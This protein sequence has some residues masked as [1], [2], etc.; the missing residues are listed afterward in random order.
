MKFTFEE[1]SPDSP[2]IDTIWRTQSEGT[3]SFTSFTSVAVSHC[4]IVVTKD[5]RGT[6]LVVRGPETV[7]TPAPVPEDAEFIGIKFKLGTFMPHLPA[8]DLVDNPI[9]LP[10]ASSKSFWLHG[11]AWQF[12][13]FENADTFVD[14]L[15]REGLLVREPIVEA[16]LRGQLKGIS[17]RSVQRRFLRAVGLTYSTVFQ[18]ERARQAMALLEQGVSILD[19]VEQAGYFDQPHLTRSLKRLVGQTPAQILRVRQPE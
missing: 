5:R 6:S 1:R 3:D 12:P 15:V 8:T 16:T 13:D 18:I 4:E 7:A 14:R 10:E 9:Y 2:F 17:L 11:S 19:T